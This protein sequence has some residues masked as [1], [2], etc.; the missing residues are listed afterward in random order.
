[1]QILRNGRIITDRRLDRLP[2]FDERSR[3]YPIRK[4]VAGLPPKTQIWE[5]DQVLDQ[6]PDGA[7][8]G[9]GITHE[10]IAVPV[11]V[12]GLDD[13][14]AK[15]IIYWGAQKVDDWPGGSYPGASPFYEGSS[16]LA[17]LEFA[18]S[19]GWFDEYRWSFT[20]EDTILGIGY[21]GPGVAGTSWM[22]GM[23]EIDSNGFIHATGSDEGGHCYLYLGVDI[24]MKAFIIHNSWGKNWGRNGRAF[25]SFDDYE[26]LR[27]NQG[28]MAFLIGRHES[29]NPPPPE[30]EPS[31]CK[32]SNGIAKFLNKTW[33]LAGKKTR[34][35]TIVENKT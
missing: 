9:F 32:F 30:P 7:C 19:L 12:R 10:L 24:Q 26:K 8:V 23:M 25:I 13:K 18:K 33:M 2:S 21:E 1:M 16:V 35:I 34:F 4:L 29:V 14:Y 5:C 28:E 17:G 15:E 6:G 3:N 22:T 27:T 20:M 11:P 31:N